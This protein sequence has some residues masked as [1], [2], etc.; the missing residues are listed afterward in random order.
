MAEED[1]DGVFYNPKELKDYETGFLR[2]EKRKL[3]NDNYASLLGLTAK[4][5]S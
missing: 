3:T 4:R 2:Q 1:I 5:N